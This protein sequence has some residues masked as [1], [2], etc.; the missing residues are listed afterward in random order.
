MSLLVAPAKTPEKPKASVGR[1][2]AVLTG[3]RRTRRGS[4]SEIN[5]QVS[6]ALP[7]R[8][9]VLGGKRFVRTA[10]G[11]V[12]EV[13][14]EVSDE[15]LSRMKTETEA[16][17]AKLGKGPAPQ[18]VPQVKA[19]PMKEGK[20]AKGKAEGRAGRGA[21]GGAG[22]PG[23]APAV[24]SAVGSSRVAMFL[25]GKAAP[26]LARGNAVLKKLRQNEQTHDAAA[27]KRAQAD[28]A[29]VI[30]FSDE[31]SK[32]NA[33]Q[34]NMVDA[35]PKPVVDE[36][37]GKQRLQQ[38][39][40]ANVPKKIEDVDNFKRDMKAQ[41]MGADVM[42]VVQGDKNAVVSTFS[43]MEKTPSPT[44]SG[45]T[46][47][48]LPPI[49]AAPGTG[50]MNLG[51]GAI[52]PL[53]KEHTDL[54]SF[55]KEGD[56]KLQEEGV[57]Q[58]Q[59]EMVD[60]GDLAAASKEKKGMEKAAKEQPIAMQKFVQTTAEK[61]DTGLKQEEKRGRDAL[62]AKR[63]GALGASAAKQKNVKSAL[64][65]K[66]EEVAGH[67][68]GIFQTTQDKVKKRLADLG[69]QAMKRFDEGN[70]RATKAFEDTVKRELDAYKDDRYSGFFGWA[71]KAK[72]WLLGM[73]DL[74]GVKAIFDRNRSNFVAAV[75]KLVET[76]SADNK[77]VIQECKDQLALAR[78]E[79][80]DYVDKL[81]PALKDIGDKTANE[82]AG[83]LAEMD[84]F[85]AKKEEDLQQQL[86]DKQQAAIKAIDEKIEKMKDEMG[87]ALAKLGKLLLWAAKKF[88]TW[89]LQ[90]FGYSLQEIEGIISKG[91]AVLKAIFTKPIQFVKNLMSAA[92]TGFKNFGKH[93][94]KHL[95]DAIFEW[96]TG[97]LEGVELPQTWDFKGII[98]VALQ[99]IGISYANLRKHLVAVL[100]E[101]VVAG[102]E[103]TF[104]LV[105]TLIT[106]GPMAAWEQLKEMAAEMRDAFVD[107]VKDFVKWKIVEEAIKWIGA[108][109]IPGAGIIKAIIGIYD[110]VV[111]FIQKAKQIIKMIGNFLGSIGEIAAGN[112]GS[113]AQ[114]MEDGLAR[115][116]SLVV[117][118]LA[119]LLRLDGITAK[120]R[121]AIQKV[122]GKVD[123]VLLKIARWIGAKAGALVRRGL[124]GDPKATPQQRLEKG[125]E[126]GTAAVNRYA[127]K[128][129][130][131]LVLRPLLAVIR[132][133][134]ALT[135]LDVELEGGRWTLVGE[136]NPKKRQPTLAEGV[137]AGNFKSKISYYPANANRGGTRM[138]A[139]P[140][141]PDNKDN[142]SA[143]SDVGAPAIW[144]KVNSRRQG[145]R[146]YV[147][148][149]LLNQGLG[150]PG[151][152][153]ANLTP[154]SF[155]M[156]KRHSAQVESKIKEAVGTKT[157]PRWFYY[158]VKVT[159]PS[160]KRALSAADAASKVAPEEGLL[161][162]GFKC[163]WYELE[164]DPGDPNK[165]IKKPGG[166]GSG[167]VYDVWHDIPPY[168]AT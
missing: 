161:T 105:K 13:P 75:D 166:L 156:N 53:Q 92:I 121:A 15:E 106:E 23:A 83:K 31:Q 80:K 145:K 138:V 12:V 168:P 21:K 43:D 143:P 4:A 58:Q 57:T 135:R 30:P 99:M 78:Q 33:G 150:G 39:L 154:I 11:K 5:G 85:V 134:H 41:H 20:Q 128:K 103:K 116:L 3:S 8:I 136:I 42:Q 149:H 137:G 63:R 73:E 37:T 71:R 68:N 163:N 130:G 140:I 131:A 120:V 54:S 87:G 40:V 142:G 2:L 70:A 74:P 94:L 22:K 164:P 44:P 17:Q 48:E 110:T 133:K 69:T 18:P 90:K 47:Q 112:I 111:F 118:F 16:A 82:M 160:S 165:L 107:A 26:V 115:G 141:G 52:A 126:E 7:L 125:I 93:F 119:K 24:L 77:R 32:S 108:I 79:I 88:F 86:K 50:S 46:P 36:N 81:G 162:S 29:V 152:T 35:K 64:Q 62:R 101:P 60:S 109:F 14:D 65:R 45:H 10:E 144:V 49:E 1:V 127:G 124:G 102:L 114:A 122:R 19:P 28:A 95:K 100:T 25:L 158:E 167:G 139:N 38:S 56:R 89:A 97:S 91:A 9:P 146:L 76:I 27:E 55:T 148:G 72:D 59:L 51:A 159:Y 61:I 155:S 98:G 6:T 129:V 147:L 84:K 104:T 157:K 151:D 34:V 67:I 123:D 153:A 96:M 66:R 132:A 113:S 117:A